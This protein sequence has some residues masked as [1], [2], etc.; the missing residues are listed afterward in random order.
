MTGEAPELRHVFVEGRVQ[1]VGYRDFARRTA[2]R[3]GVRGWARNRLDGTVEVLAVGTAAS[4]ESFLADLRH[5]PG[6]VS[7]LRVATSATL[8]G[9]TPEVFVIRPTF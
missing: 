9:E 4:L 2:R 8:D 3:L 7:T 1:G 5:G 6:V